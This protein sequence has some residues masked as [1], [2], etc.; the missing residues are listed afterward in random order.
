MNVRD[1][2]TATSTAAVLAALAGAPLVPIAPAL[3]AAPPVPARAAWPLKPVRLIVPQS[4]GGSTDLVARPLATHLSSALGQNVL[5]DNRPGA[6]SVIGTEIVARAA[7]DGHTLLAVAASFTATPALHAKLPFDSQR[8][9]APITVLSAFPNLLVVHPSLPVKTVQELLALARAKPGV[10]NYGTS[11][12]A[13]GTHMSMELFMHLTGTRLVHVPYK[14]GAPSVQALM[15]NEVQVNM[16]T[17]STSLPQVRAGRLRAL[18]TTGARR[19]AVLPELPTVA[20]SGVPGFEYSSWTGLLAPAKTPRPVIERV[21]AEAVKAVNNPEM[22]AL[23]ATEGAE[24]VGSTP[25]QFAAQIN[26]EIAR[27]TQVVKA[28]GI[29]AD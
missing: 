7:P 12:A 19:A 21:H 9:F 28:A 6:G 4:A 29:R 25:A 17:I 27:W 13:T 1:A 22:K 3:A 14:G 5:V 23:L 16:A 24:P 18:A 26:A 15:T 10:L 2:A 8:D 11:G 20:E